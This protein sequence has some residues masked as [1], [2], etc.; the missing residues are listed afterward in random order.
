MNPHH[1]DTLTIHTAFMAA[2][3]VSIEN[4]MSNTAY[5]EAEIKRA[6][7]NNSRRIVLLAD[8]TKF[9]RDALIS[10]CSLE[11]VSAVVTDREP[12]AEFMRFFHSY[13]TKI[14]F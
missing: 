12:T 1:I 14:L 13:G 10:Y 3:G 5:F 2:T 11:K 9:G 7:C 6:I 8:H 4:G